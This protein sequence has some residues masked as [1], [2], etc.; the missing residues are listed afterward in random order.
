MP[1]QEEEEERSWK[2]ALRCSNLISEST[3][4]AGFREMTVLVECGRA[5][6]KL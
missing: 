2:S 6:R 1:I 4:T 3:N 5:S